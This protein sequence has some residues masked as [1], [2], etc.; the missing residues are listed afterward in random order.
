MRDLIKCCNCGYIG[1]VEKGSDVCPQCKN[2][3]S[4]AWLDENNQEVYYEGEIM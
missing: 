2:D 3:K 1:T 4:L